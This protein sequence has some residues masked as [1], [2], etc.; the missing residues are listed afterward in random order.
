MS[1]RR[2][3]SMPPSGLCTKRTVA[4][5]R[6]TPAAGIVLSGLIVLSACGR[7]EPD[8][9][10]GPG[11]SSSS[12]Q[13]SKLGPNPSDP[14][15]PPHDRAGRN[16]R[17]GESVGASAAEDGP[18]RCGRLSVERLR[19]GRFHRAVVRVPGPPRV[20]ASFSEETVTVSYRIGDLP[21][22]CKPVSLTLA[23]DS[24]SDRIPPYSHEI[25]LEGRTSGTS[26]FEL[27]SVI[28]STPQVLKATAFASGGRPSR[29][30]NARISR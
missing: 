4:A 28:E 10:A 15:K 17:Q 13:A 5:I 12:D 22:A 1:N 3:R 14:T 27:P 11:K 16:S 23:V 7:A 6:R 20:R 19:D 26:R 21:A 29:A 2:L 24:Q 18:R 30:T 8:P 9:A 25:R